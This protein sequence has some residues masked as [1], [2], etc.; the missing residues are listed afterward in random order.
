MVDPLAEFVQ[1]LGHTG[2]KTQ[3]PGNKARHD[4]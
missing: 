2:I 1:F 4:E 3:M